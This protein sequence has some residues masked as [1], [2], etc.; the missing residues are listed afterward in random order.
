MGKGEGS[1]LFPRRGVLGCQSSWAQALSPV[2]LLSD[3]ETEAQRGLSFPMA[4]A[5]LPD[6][7]AGPETT[8]PSRSIR[9]FKG[10]DHSRDGTGSW[11]DRSWAQPAQPH[12]LLGHLRTPGHQTAVYFPFSSHSALESLQV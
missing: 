7:A 6:S 4:I 3:E 2:F 1:A 11:V 5:G 8:A 12:S 9:G 10:S